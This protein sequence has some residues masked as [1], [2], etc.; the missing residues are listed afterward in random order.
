MST[1]RRMLCIYIFALVACTFA[2]GKQFRSLITTQSGQDEEAQRKKSEVVPEH[3]VYGQ[4]FSLL[5]ALDN[6]ADYQQQAGLSDEQAAAL[7]KIAIDC[8]REIEQQDTKARK[9]IN[10]FRDKLAKIKPK[11]G[12]SL[13]PPPAELAAMQKERNAIILR[14][15]DRLRVALGEEKF[16]RVDQAGRKIVKINVTPAP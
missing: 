10:A 16:Q 4:M 11:P 12:T 9:V 14:A 13:P 15:R 8:Q 5:V 3:I 2:F 1:K 6:A 7:K